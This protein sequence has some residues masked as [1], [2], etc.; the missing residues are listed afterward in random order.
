YSIFQFRD[1]LAR[2][3]MVPRIDVFAL[4]AETP[5]EEAI[6]EVVAAGHSRIPVYS[7]TIDNIVGLIY[8]KDLLRVWREGATNKTLRDLLRPAHFIPE[9]KALDELL[10]ELQQQRIHMAVVVDEYGGTAGLVTLEDI[11]EEIV[12]EIRDEYDTTEESPYQKI[13]DDEYIFDG[14]T[15]INDVNELLDLKLPSDDADTIGGYVY[16][17][18]GRVPASG[19][20]LTEDNVVGVRAVFQVSS[21]RVVACLLG[22]NL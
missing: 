7:E 11:V 13:N 6:N 2:E 14:G 15:N 16:G 21:G 5:F 22:E 9:A 19:D 3:V 4:D 18:L 17:Q 8:A 20:Q 10:A 1:T 12:G